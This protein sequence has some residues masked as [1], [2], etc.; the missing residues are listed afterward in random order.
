MKNNFLVFFILFFSVFKIFSYEGVVTDNK[1]RIRT[2]P[3][4]KYSNIIKVAN[5]GEKYIV[6]A[7]TS[8]FDSIDGYTDCWYRIKINE[9]YG[10]IYGGYFDVSN[11]NEELSTYTKSEFFCL[12]L[13]SC[14][15]I[16]GFKDSSECTNVVNKG[17]LIKTKNGTG[18]SN[19]SSVGL[20]N[21]Y[22]FD[23]NGFQITALNGGENFYYWTEIEITKDFKNPFNLKFGMTKNQLNEIFGY[24]FNLD[25]T[26]SM[27]IGEF[28]GNFY[29]TN[30]KLSKI[31]IT[32]GYW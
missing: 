15:E 26:F 10:F 32:N 27:Q 3:S 14:L 19:D 17:K 31:K 24:D 11:S 29:F 1:V 4:L 25:D 16:I 28:Y 13:W 5:K 18:Y 30:G 21:Y 6:D 20:K 8:D 22:V 2:A 12:L 7:K 9:E 23:V